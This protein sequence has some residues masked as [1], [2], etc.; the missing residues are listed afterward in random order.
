MKC[1]PSSRMLFRCCVW[2]EATDCN[3][4][5]YGVVILFLSFFLARKKRRN[6]FCS[7]LSTGVR[8]K[9][10]DPLE[11]DA[12][13]RYIYLY[14]YIYVHVR[15]FLDGCNAPKQRETKHTEKEGCYLQLRPEEYRLFSKLEEW[16]VD[17]TSRRTSL[18][19]IRLIDR[20]ATIIIRTHDRIAE[21]KCQMGK[22]VLD[23]IVTHL[24]NGHDR[25][26][27]SCLK[28]R[29][30]KKRGREIRIFFLFSKHKRHTTH[31]LVG[32]ENPS[33]NDRHSQLYL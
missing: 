2:C 19:P 33:P 17:E 13:R 3:A 22:I 30:E 12:C 8:K 21:R 16:K 29:Q 23:N 9:K 24:W 26:G 18:L 15:F 6:V 7:P 25:Y 1:G 32:G 10:R 28:P 14:L 5:P 11:K 27:Q 20:L 31:Q 4:V